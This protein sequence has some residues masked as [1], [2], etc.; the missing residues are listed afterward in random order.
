MLWATPFITLMIK[1][2]S[3]TIFSY[4]IQF[5]Q[6]YSYQYIH[7]YYC[8]PISFFIS[9][10]ADIT[11]DAP[12][13]TSLQT[14][15]FETTVT[16]T[17]GP[18]N[19]TPTT[20]NF[21]MTTRAGSSANTQK[22]HTVTDVS[23]VT[24]SATS[25]LHVNGTSTRSIINV[26]TDAETTTSNKNVTN[27]EGI[28]EILTTTLRTTGSKDKYTTTVSPS[29][30]SVAGYQPTSIKPAIQND[31]KTTLQL[32]AGQ[33]YPLLTQDHIDQTNNTTPMLNLSEII[34]VPGKNRSMTLGNLLT[35]VISKTKQTKNVTT[36][37]NVMHSTSLPSTRYCDDEEE[38]TDVNEHLGDIL[39]I[40]GQNGTKLTNFSN[41]LDHVVLHANRTTNPC[42]KHP[43]SGLGTGDGGYQ[44]KGNKTDKFPVTEVKFQ[45]SALNPGSVS[46][47]LTIRNTFSCASLWNS[48]TFLELRTTF[49]EQLKLNREI[50]NDQE[51][52]QSNTTLKTIDTHGK[53]N[54]NSSI[55]NS[56][57]WCYP[58]SKQ[59]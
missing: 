7:Y 50:G 52:V 45:V 1:M 15:P 37:N 42:I 36:N 39:Q 14:T 38:Y 57:L 47:G 40:N 28:K 13:S 18:T 58:N 22:P 8:I 53:Q 44:H 20:N 33:K 54:V 35:D 30:D 55:P 9:F 27:T 49:G 17:N 34:A 11:T 48:L 41:I 43:V 19:T 5:M 16:V 59:Q 24:T 32:H 12:C 4:L 26:T 2:H 25:A 10:L 29:D 23:M 3:G 31:V 56:S 46:L 51:L 6:I 21:S